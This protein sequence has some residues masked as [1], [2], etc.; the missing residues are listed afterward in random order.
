MPMKE[1][2]RDEKHVWRAISLTEEMPRAAVLLELTKVLHVAV[3][4][5]RHRLLS[6]LWKD[7]E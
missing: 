2:I 4:Q 3:T 6:S 1:H 5:M 7:I